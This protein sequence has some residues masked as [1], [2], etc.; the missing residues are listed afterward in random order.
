MNNI[1]KKIKKTKNYEELIT[2]IKE[3]PYI[4]KTKKVIGGIYFY[5]KEIPAFGKY[6]RQWFMPE[7]NF[8]PANKLKY[9]QELLIT[10][11]LE[12]KSMYGTKLAIKNN[13]WF[14]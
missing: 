11:I 3:L 7:P 4:K 14:K 8:Y 10:T 13:L 1:F 2:I 9:I 5:G 12:A 6:R